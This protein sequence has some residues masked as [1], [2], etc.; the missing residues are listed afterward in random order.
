V[1]EDLRFEGIE[2]NGFLKMMERAGAPLNIVILGGKTFKEDYREGK[3]SD[4]LV[5]WEIEEVSDRQGEGPTGFR[6]MF[7]TLC[8]SSVLGQT[9]HDP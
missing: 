9:G 8:P 4:G 7:Q 2:A 3:V 1:E 5:I 6:Q